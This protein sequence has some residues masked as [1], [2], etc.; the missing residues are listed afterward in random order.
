MA[1]LILGIITFSALAIISNVQSDTNE[2]S[3]GS[4]TIEISEDKFK[5]TSDDVIVS[6]DAIDKNPTITNIGTT[7]CYI[8]AYVG[9]SDVEFENE[10]LNINICNGWYISD[11]GYYYYPNPIAP[12]ESVTLFDKISVY[13]TDKFECDVFVYAESIDAND[14]D[15]VTAWGL[16]D[17]IPAQTAAQTA[18]VIIDV[19]GL[20]NTVVDTLTYTIEAGTKMTNSYLWDLV[21]AEGYSVTGV[22]GSGKNTIAQAGKTYNFEAET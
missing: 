4:Q 14:N 12:N 1:A 21:E 11:D 3:I 10:H 7:N 16:F 13:N 20:D 9:C 19:L 22:F 6:G 15:Y 8:R 18:T 5:I 2:F 17:I